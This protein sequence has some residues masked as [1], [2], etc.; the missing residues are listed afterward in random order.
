M[1]KKT[2]KYEDFDGNEREE[3]FW[4]GLTKAELIDL[5]TS[6]SGGIQSTVKKIMESQNVNDTMDLFKKIILLA[7]GEKSADGRNFVKNDE[8]RENFKSTQAYSELYMELLQSEDAAVN[9]ITGIMPKGIDVDEAKKQYE[10]QK[11]QNS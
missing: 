4:F 7:Y 6:V 10:L 8:I 5:E 2:I 9:F 3:T 1:L 11:K